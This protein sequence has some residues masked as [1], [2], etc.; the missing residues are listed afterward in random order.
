MTDK[1]TMQVLLSLRVFYAHELLILIRAKSMKKWHNLMLA[2]AITLAYT[3]GHSAPVINLQRKPN[4][5]ITRPLPTNIFNAY[6]AACPNTKITVKN[7]RTNNK[8]N[9]HNQAEPYIECTLREATRIVQLIAENNAEIREIIAISKERKDKTTIQNLENML[10]SQAEMISIQQHAGA[11]FT[12]FARQ[13]KNTN[14]VHELGHK[15]HD[16]GLAQLHLSNIDLLASV[17]P[18]GLFQAVSILE[19]E[20]IEWD[21]NTGRKLLCNWG[22]L[23]VETLGLITSQTYCHAIVN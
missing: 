16:L 11:A 6:L 3:I 22:I 5:I 19:K 8:H 7:H 12:K 2:V 4:T 23:E 20:G 18:D 14:K 15:Y 10:I 1:S 17:K 9:E 21:S 13:S